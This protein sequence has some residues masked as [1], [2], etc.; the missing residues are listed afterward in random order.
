MQRNAKKHQRLV[1]VIKTIKNSLIARQPPC[2]PE[3]PALHLTATRP[4]RLV[5]WKSQLKLSCNQLSMM[6]HKHLTQSV[7]HSTQTLFE[8]ISGNER[9]LGC[10]MQTHDTDCTQ[11]H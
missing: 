7:R 11:F 6:S 4:V 8:A 5:Q 10:K 3:F 9:A 1:I 2:Y